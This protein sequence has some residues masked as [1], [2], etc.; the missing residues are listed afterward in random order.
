VENVPDTNLSSFGDT[1]QNSELVLLFLVQNQP[2][3]VVGDRKIGMKY[4]PSVLL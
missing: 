2:Q 1:S 3:D 4:R